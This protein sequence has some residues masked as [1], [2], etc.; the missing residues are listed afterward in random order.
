MNNPYR[1]LPPLPALIG[2]E[3]AARLGSFSRAAE[4]LNLTQSAVSHQVRALEAHLGQPLFRRIGRRIELTDAG[5]D[6]LATAQDALE[7]VR[8][9]VRRL[10]AYTKPG[11]VIVMMSPALAQG[12]FLPRL[13]RLRADLPGVEP[14]LHTATGAWVPEEA[15]IDIVISQSPWRDEGTVSLPLLDDRLWPLAAPEVAARLPALADAARLDTAPLLHDE[16]PDDWQ[17]WFAQVASARQEFTSGLNFSDT[18]VMLQA[19]ALGHGIC[20][21]SERLA[22][23]YLANGTLVRVAETPLDTS[24]RFYLSAWR[25]NFGREAVTALWDWLAGQDA[26]ALPALRD[27]GFA[28]DP[29][30]EDPRSGI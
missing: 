18:G 20:L 21:G 15:E 30:P 9:G 17:K 11:S 26:E 28:H 27:R 19:A 2:F 10:H 22:D 14:W 29:R 5:T 1:S 3:A 7:T 4:E 23:S 25:R 24:G 13:A 6:L 8:Y 12:W 16:S